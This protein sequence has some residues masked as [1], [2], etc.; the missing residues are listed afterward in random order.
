MIERD[1]T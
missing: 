1:K